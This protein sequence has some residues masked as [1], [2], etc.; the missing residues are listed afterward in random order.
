[1]ELTANQ[2][3]AIEYDGGHL[4][5]IACAGSGK[6]ETLSRRIARLVASGEARESIV[7]FTFTEH[8]ATELKRRIRRCLENDL[9]D[10]P[11]IGDLYVGTI[12][13]FCLRL[14]RELDA[15]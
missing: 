3:R 12:H 5:I 11:A 4:R 10:D 9:P 8:A 2:K 14:L 7:A 1:M 13:S 6:T 15:E